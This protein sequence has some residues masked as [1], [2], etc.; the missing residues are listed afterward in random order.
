MRGEGEHGDPTEDLRRQ[1]TAERHRTDWLI[2]LLSQ[3]GSALARIE[4]R[5]SAIEASIASRLTPMQ[6][7]KI[8]V[9]LALPILVL[10]LTGNVELARRFVNLP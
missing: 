4:Q 7:A 10:L 1:L 9:G 8:L 6:W 2:Q 3:H 5:C